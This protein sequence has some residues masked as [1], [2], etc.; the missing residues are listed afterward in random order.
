MLSSYGPAAP[1]SLW[2]SSC[3]VAMIVWE[4][5][6]FVGTHGFLA[7][8]GFYQCCMLLNIGFKIVIFFYSMHIIE[9]KNSVIREIGGFF[10]VLFVSLI[11]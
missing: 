2:V 11:K 7:A 4:H 6:A 3:S 9:E 8:L 1:V 5:L 10:F